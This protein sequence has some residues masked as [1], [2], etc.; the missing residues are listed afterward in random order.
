M[1]RKRGSKPFK[2]DLVVLVEEGF[3]PHQLVF[4]KAKLGR[5]DY[6]VHLIR[7]PA[8]DDGRG[9]SRV[10]Q[11]PGDGDLAWRAAMLSAYLLEQLNQL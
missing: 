2:A 3:D 11:R 1:R 7:P 9:H 5:A 8:P 4:A 10:P 6:A